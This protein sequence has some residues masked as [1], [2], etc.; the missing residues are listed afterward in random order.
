[1]SSNLSS[2][3]NQRI[4]LEFMESSPSG[5]QTTIPIQEPASTDLDFKM[6]EQVSEDNAS[7]LSSV[8]HPRIVTCQGSIACDAAGNEIKL[9][10]ALLDLVESFKCLPNVVA[11]AYFLQLLDVIEYLHQ[12]ADLYHGDLNVQN[13]LVDE[14]FNLRV[15]GVVSTK[16]VTPAETDVSAST[17]CVEEFSC[18]EIWK[19]ETSN[20]FHKNTFALGVILFEMVAGFKPFE[21]ARPEDPIYNLLILN[22][23]E[24]FWQ[25]HE[26]L[27]TEMTG[28]TPAKEHFSPEFRGIINS[29]LAYEAGD[30]L[31][32]TADIRKHA[33]CQGIA[34]NDQ[35]LSTLMKEI[36]KKMCL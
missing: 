26:A 24:E 19:G 17:T 12:S 18:P 1:M 5:S 2:A 13:I 11:K 14:T 22:K 20:T 35:S 25:F 23:E 31:K 7:L 6:N 15:T 29:M 3:N 9:K 4:K 8:C 10:G 34:L 36:A 21:S 28:L 30:R 32:D 33:W 27:K 16:N